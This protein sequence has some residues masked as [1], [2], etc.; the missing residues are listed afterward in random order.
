MDILKKAD[1]IVNSGSFEKERD[2]GPFQQ[3]MTKAARIATEL[4]PTDPATGSMY[5]LRTIDAE[6]MYK[7]LMALKLCRISYSA[8]HE[9][10][11]L[12]LV[13]YTASLNDLTNGSAKSM[14]PTIFE[15]PAKQMEV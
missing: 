2:Y 3:S 11:Y 4:L 6:T 14:K 8:A 13:A 15:S 1:E 12:D 9:D 5:P 7:C 10:S